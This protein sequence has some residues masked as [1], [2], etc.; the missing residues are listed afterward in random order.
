[1]TAAHDALAGLRQSARDP[2]SRAAGGPEA[3]GRA[4]VVRR[5]ENLGAIASR[6]DTTV[7]TLVERN[8]IANPNLIRVGQVLLIDAQAVGRAEEP[9]VPRPTDR[10][11]YVV[12]PGDT[13]SGVAALFNT[14]VQKL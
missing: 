12:R 8:Q 14:T 7:R 3:A 2:G 1:M 4:H 9:V 5:R 10:S 13:L 6:Y 11:V